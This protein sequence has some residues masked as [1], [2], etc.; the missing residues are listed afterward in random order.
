MAWPA[1]NEVFWSDPLAG[2]RNRVKFLSTSPNLCLQGV[3][4]FNN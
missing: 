3:H 1:G 4:S 2:G